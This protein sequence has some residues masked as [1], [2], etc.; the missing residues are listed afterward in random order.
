MGL[1]EQMELA[2]TSSLDQA[3]LTWMGLAGI[4]ELVLTNLWIDLWTHFSVGVSESQTELRTDTLQGNMGKSSCFNIK[5]VLQ[6][7]C[8]EETD[9]ISLII[10]ALGLI[11]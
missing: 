3:L 10:L 8:F 2:L 5:P 4:T 1:L 6:A 7:N 11:E 9:T